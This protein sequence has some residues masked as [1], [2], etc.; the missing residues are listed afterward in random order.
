MFLK[1]IFL[2]FLIGFSYNF[3]HPIAELN[4]VSSSYNLHIILFL[5][6]LKGIQVVRIEF[7]FI[8][9]IANIRCFILIAVEMFHNIIGI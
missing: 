8:L 4:I 5:I 2:S 3:Q 9:K 6:F 7:F 1:K